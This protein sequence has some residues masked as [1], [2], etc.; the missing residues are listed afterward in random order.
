MVVRARSSV[1]KPDNF[2]VGEI[3][4]ITGTTSTVKRS[5]GEYVTEELQIEATDGFFL[6]PSGSQ[7][8]DW[9]ALN[10]NIP[11]IHVAK[12]SKLWDGH[13][14][15]KYDLYEVLDAANHDAI[16]NVIPTEHIRIG[17]FEEWAK[18]GDADTIQFIQ[19]HR[20]PLELARKVIKFHKK[21]TAQKLT[22]NPYRLLSFY[23]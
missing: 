18:N 7:I 13:V 4:E 8:V 22:E 1:I 2:E 10:K 14:K 15:G 21:N 23:W 16:S 5:F 20:I 11:G 3:W 17:L 6:Q 12:A 9:I 19:Q